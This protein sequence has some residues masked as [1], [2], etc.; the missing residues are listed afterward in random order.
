[1]MA[2]LKSLSDNSNS[3][4]TLVF[5]SVEYLFHF[6]CDLGI[7]DFLLKPRYLQIMVQDSG[8]LCVC[9]LPFT[10]LW[11]G[12]EGVSLFSW[13]THS[14]LHSPMPL[15]RNGEKLLITGVGVEAWDP[16]VSLNTVGERNTLIT[17]TLS[18]VQGPASSGFLQQLVPTFSSSD[19]FCM[20]CYSSLSLNTG[21]QVTKSVNLALIYQ[22]EDPSWTTF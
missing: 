5:V 10:L 18:A 7:S 4:I 20:Y 12:K 1:M 19:F 14:G 13:G 21:R 2:T 3:S 9:W 6:I 16:C 8:P 17:S 11:E 22:C 15:T